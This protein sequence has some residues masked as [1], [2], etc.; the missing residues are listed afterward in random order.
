[1][2]TTP[3]LALLGGE[4]VRKKPIPYHAIIEEE[5]IHAVNEV[6]QN[7]KL[8]GFY[9]NFL[10]G[11]KVRQFEEAFANYHGIKNAISVNSGT[12]A[13]HVALAAL[14]IGPGDEVIVPAYTFTATASSVLMANAVPVF[15]DIDAKSYNIN[16]SEIEKLITPSTKAIIAVHL[17][18][19]PAEMDAI[20]SIAK[21]HNLKVVEDCAQA[22][23]AM[24]KNKLVGTIG[25]VGCFSFVETKNMVTGEG[26]MII[27]DDEKTAERCRLIRNHGESWMQGKPRPYLSNILGYNFRMTEIEAAI[28]IEQLKKLDRFNKARNEYTL[29]IA[30]S[31]KKYKGLL[32]PHIEPYVK[33]VS[34]VLCL[35]YNQDVF[36]IP[37]EKF[38]QAVNAEGIS[39]SVG[40]PHPLYLNPLFKEKIVYGENGCPYTCKHYKGKVDY[41][42]GI[43]PIAEEICKKAIWIRDARLPATVE[44]MKG[45][46]KIFEKVI[47]N[48]DELK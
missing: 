7:K 8:S 22:P 21:K 24:Y 26:G 33:A 43:C 41:R 23:G 5:E 36:G 48:I 46:V 30:N 6:L 17:L 28:G 1:M 9:L 3:K 19:N 40:Y 35:Q 12:A 45:I 44:D 39:V 34:H 32:L 4:P 15:C 37:R 47:K 18:G 16:P 20:M 27:T 42:E 14:N 31:L 25:H 11:E 38:I 10:G 2:K 13:L 29:G